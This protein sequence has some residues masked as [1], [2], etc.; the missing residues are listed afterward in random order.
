MN[1]KAVLSAL[2]GTAF[3]VFGLPYVLAVFRMAPNGTETLLLVVVLWTACW[4]TSSRLKRRRR[5]SR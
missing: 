4:A 1:A 3:L 5:L 2:V